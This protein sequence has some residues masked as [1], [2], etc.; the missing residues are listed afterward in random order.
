[1]ENLNKKLLR[2]LYL[3]LFF[4][5]TIACSAR[6]Y[7]EQKENPDTTQL[8]SSIRHGKLSNG[9]TYFVKPIPGS[10]PGIHMEFIHLAGANQEDP[11]QENFAHAV[12]HLAFKSTKNFP[13]GAF[14]SKLLESLGGNFKVG[15]G[16][17]KNYTAFT[18]SN[19]EGSREGTKAGFIW[20]RDIVTNLEVTPENVESVRGEVREELLSKVGTEMQERIAKAKMD[21]KFFPCETKEMDLLSHHERFY[22]EDILRFYKDWYHPENFALVIVG[23]INDPE[24][25]LQL[26]KD[27]FSSLKSST[28]PRKPKN[29]D[30][31][32]YSQ[33]PNFVVVKREKD[34]KRFLENRTAT[35]HMI[36]KYP[37]LKQSPQNIKGLKDL[38]K[39]EL[40][41]DIL[42]GRFME[43]SNNYGFNLVNTKPFFLVGQLPRV[44]LA[45]SFEEGTGER[46]IKTIGKLL[47]QLS[48]H[49]ISEVEF[50]RFRSDQLSKTKENINSPTRY[51]TEEIRKYLQGEPL[52][53]EKNDYLV[54]YLESLTLDELNS[55]I[56][57]H[58]EKMPE[59]IGII[60]P[61]GHKA[62]SYREKEVRQW[63]T[64]AFD[65]PVEPFEEP[66]VRNLMTGQQVEALQRISSLDKGTDETGSRVFILNNGIK[67][68]LQQESRKDT[69][70][71]YPINLHGFSIGGA[72]FL[73]KEDY[74]SAINAPS[75]VFHSGVNN[76]SKFEVDRI[77]FRTGLYPGVV[78]SYID[79]AEHGIYGTT[80]MENIET[81]M[82]LVY[83]YLTVPNRSREAFEDWK[84][85][86]T[87]NYLNYPGSLYHDDYNNTLHT[88]TGNKFLKKVY[89]RR[90]LPDG[91]DRYI[92][93]EKT[94]L[95]TAFD[96]YTRFFNNAKDFT[97]LITGNFEVDQILPLAEKYL[98]NLRTSGSFE[99][100]EAS[101]DGLPEGPSFQIFSNEGNYSMQN[102]SYGS[103]YIHEVEDVN[104]W[105]E[106]IKVNALGEVLRQKMW[107]L[108]FE[109]GYGIYGPMGSAQY[110]PELQR[111][112]IRT[113]L[114]CQPKDFA[115]L[116]KEVREIFSDIKA[117]RIS[118][119]ELRP[120]LEIMHLFNFSDRA[121]RLGIQVHNL[122]K[123][124]RF[125][126]PWIDE[127]KAEEFTMN[128]TVKDIQEV[129][130]KY[131]KE[132]NF[133]ELVIRDE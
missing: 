21:G 44:E 107:D 35:I 122:Y 13:S 47:N 126:Y 55:F 17:S 123:H 4:T 52:P 83:L 62:L 48:T 75:I 124:Y 3:I 56:A 16:N 8:D 106:H 109:K 76:M 108:R 118:T 54:Q 50:E 133:H 80:N 19:P 121:H 36:L 94:D 29:C 27:N 18:F 45:Y 67:L 37:S 38:K 30:S 89:N 46:S 102:Y 110:H 85:E 99:Y 101:E 87:E 78:S 9:L 39:F 74:W 114:Y 6:E 112:E 113:Y 117:G 1:M 82:Q 64:E 68:V 129:A 2:P 71:P 23:D 5:I 120:A 26:I 7:V 130:Q 66:V 73:P 93:I 90:G 53:G 128:L 84:Q 79:Y 41:L 15:A 63:L 96:I 105:Q 103:F 20:F 65:A 97:F 95:N 42:H 69:I 77:L 127:E 131:L 58:L 31:L 119:S 32:Y 88:I 91:T 24:D 98:G 22:T 43:A 11:D 14:N 57:A 92:S 51:W 70:S 132:E 111:Y 49:G 104:D 28:K 100:A 40:M 116:Q 59:D 81:M 25:M 60:A 61:E 34:P 10:E 86:S 115:K 72:N 125:E 12:E 33:S